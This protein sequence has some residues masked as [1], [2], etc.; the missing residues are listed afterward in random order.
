MSTNQSGQVIVRKSDLAVVKL[1]SLSTSVP[2]TT[3]LWVGNVKY[4]FFFQTRAWDRTSLL[5]ATWSRINFNVWIHW[6]Q[7]RMTSMGIVRLGHWSPLL[8]FIFQKNGIWQNWK[9]L[10][11]CIYS[12]EKKWSWWLPWMERNSVLISQWFCLGFLMDVQ[13]IKLITCHTCHLTFH[14]GNYC[15][16]KDYTLN[17]QLTIEGIFCADAQIGYF[18]FILGMK[19]SNQIDE[20]SWVCSRMMRTLI[21]CCQ[22]GIMTCFSS[23]TTILMYACT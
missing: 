3:G 13:W 12:L 17:S 2:Y 7:K 14:E 10:S 9:Q 21:K 1:G 20:N 8:P 11:I 15:W 16:L 6:F 22:W 5:Q 23:C 4:E 19:F 18:E